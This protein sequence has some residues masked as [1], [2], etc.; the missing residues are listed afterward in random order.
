MKI[1]TLKVGSDS[2]KMRLGEGALGI[3]LW[4]WRKSPCRQ[5]YLTVFGE[6]H[7]DITG[8]AESFG[9]MPAGKNKRGETVLVKDKDDLDYSDAQKSF[10]YVRPDFDRG[11]YLPIEAEYHDK[12]FPY[13][14]L[15]NVPQQKGLLPVSNGMK[16]VYIAAPYNHVDFRPN[17]ILLIYRIAEKNKWYNSVVTSY[18]VI[19]NVFWVKHGGRPEIGFEDFVKM[20]G[21]KTVY[22]RGELRDIYDKK[23]FV[24]II[25]ALYNGYLGEG[26]NINYGWLKENGL[27]EGHPYQ[28]IL[29]R[30]EVI[31]IL[32][33]GGTDAGDL[34]I[35]KS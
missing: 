17:D 13:S 15:K 18:G 4:E 10:P 23:R 35:D 2:E 22:P 7:E 1:G 29:N 3:A 14:C 34:V 32:R 9:F 26:N 21:N 8:L 16:K 28:N 24:L 25:T 33:Q 11:H 5:I 6:K 30:D 12:M 20:A 19:L 27:F 31:R